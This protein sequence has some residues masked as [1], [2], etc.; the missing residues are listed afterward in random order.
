MLTAAAGDRSAAILFVGAH[1]A[2][3][4]LI[5]GIAGNEGAA[6]AP[7]FLLLAAAWLLAWRCV[8]VLS[9]LRPQRALARH[10][11]C[12]CSSRRSSAPGS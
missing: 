12:A 7:F 11:R 6:R 3:W 8:A 5:A 9:A 1:G 10:R 4:L 2:A